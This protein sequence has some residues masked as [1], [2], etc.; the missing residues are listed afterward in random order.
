MYLI[1]FYIINLI[2]ILLKVGLIKSG[3]PISILRK[4]QNESFII[5]SVVAFYT[6]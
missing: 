2:D 5:S 6:F 3:D 1:A 4:L